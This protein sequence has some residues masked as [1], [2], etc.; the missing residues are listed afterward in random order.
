MDR[1][2]VLFAEAGGR[3][4]QTYIASGNVIFE[5]NASPA[6]LEKKIEAHLA[7]SLGF[8]VPTL[9]RS[10]PEMIA[11]AERNAFP[12]APAL[13]AGGAL[14]VGFLKADTTKVAANAIAALGTDGN[15]FA[16][17]GREI[18]WRAEDR[19]SVLEIPIAT[20]EKA[21]GCHTTFRN[22]STVRKLAERYCR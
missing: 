6:T 17:I 21:V 8:D 14:Y 20:F 13:T 18:Y 12:K 5:S 9:L 4:V 22:V 2:R 11:V 16:L 1:L 10:A 15:T 7:R 3:D 19:R